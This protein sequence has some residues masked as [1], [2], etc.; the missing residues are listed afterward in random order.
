LPIAVPQE[1]NYLEHGSK[2]IALGFEEIR[3]IE[4]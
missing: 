3:A 4:T 1:S 2:R